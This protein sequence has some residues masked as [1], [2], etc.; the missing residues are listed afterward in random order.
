[1]SIKKLCQLQRDEAIKYIEQYKKFFVR[2]RSGVWNKY[3]DIDYK[4]AI[5]G[6]KNS[7]FGAD[8][9]IDKTNKILLVSCPC[10]SDMW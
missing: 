2:Y 7:P 6:V 1:M 10:Q 8:V 3:E 9:F 4:K 5:E